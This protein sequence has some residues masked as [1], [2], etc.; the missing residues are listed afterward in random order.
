[1]INVLHLYYD[2]NVW[3]ISIHTLTVISEG[4]FNQ[5]PLKRAYMAL[6]FFNP[7]IYKGLQRSNTIM[8]QFMTYAMTYLLLKL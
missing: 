7:F 1:M 5:N 6:I 3:E 2:L 8:S 4:V